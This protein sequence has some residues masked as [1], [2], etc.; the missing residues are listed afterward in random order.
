MKN[1]QHTTYYSRKKRTTYRL[2]YLWAMVKVF[3]M[4]DC[5]GRSDKILSL[6]KAEQAMRRAVD[7]TKDDPKFLIDVNHYFVCRLLKNAGKLEKSLCE[8]SFNRAYR[9]TEIILKAHPRRGLI[10]TYRLMLLA[11]ADRQSK[12]RN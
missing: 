4:K 5:I 10:Y 1:I 6:L 2:L 11:I 8:D 7:M 9:T 3:R 12:F